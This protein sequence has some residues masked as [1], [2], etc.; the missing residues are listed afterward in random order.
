MLTSQQA[1]KSPPTEVSG[2]SLC[3]GSG[4]KRLQSNK[5]LLQC[6]PPYPFA[7]SCHASSQ[8]GGKPMFSTEFQD[9]FSGDLALWNL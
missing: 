3:K 5:S 4:R 2:L 1:K 7:H 8:D 9:G 6:T